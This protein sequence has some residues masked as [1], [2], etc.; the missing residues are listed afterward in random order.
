[1]HSRIDFVVVCVVHEV[2]LADHGNLHLGSLGCAIGVMELNHFKFVHAEDS[3]RLLGRFRLWYFR[4]ELGK[5]VLALH[6]RRLVA[7]GK[8]GVI[9]G[10]SL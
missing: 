4:T 5:G 7:G 3:L 10:R 8:I 6:L 2:D 1:M 9:G